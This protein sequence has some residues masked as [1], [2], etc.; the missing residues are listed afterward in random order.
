MQ[1]LKTSNHQTL[2]KNSATEVIKA[3]TSSTQPKK[4]YTKEYKAQ[5][6]GVYKSGVYDSVMSCATAYG[7][8]DKTL[9]NWLKQHNKQISPDAITQQQSEIVSLK[10]E[11]TKAKMENDILKKAAIYF[12]SQAQ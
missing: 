11:L 5:V 8:T 12:A 10:K 4:P 1:T 7:I 3:E 2:T 9:Y 6:V